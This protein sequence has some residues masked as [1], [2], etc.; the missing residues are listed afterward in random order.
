[1]IENMW[2]L[3]CL[4][5]LLAW[6]VSS[7]TP[8]LMSAR[9]KPLEI[10]VYQ[11]LG[12]TAF[13]LGLLVYLRFDIL[14]DIRGMLL[15]MCIGVTGMSGQVLYIQALKQAPLSRLSV[16]TSLY[17]AISIFL[18]VVFVGENVPLHR[19]LG[20]VCAIAS[21]VVLVSGKASVS[22]EKEVPARRWMI[23]AVGALLLWGFWA[24]L[25]KLALQT[26][27]PS[28]VIVYE[29]L[30]SGLVIAWA[31]YSLRFQ[32][33]KNVDAV[34]TCTLTSIMGMFAVFSYIYA[35]QTGPVSAVTVIT[36]MYPLITLFLA[37]IVLKERLNRRQMA[38]AIVALL[39][40]ATMVI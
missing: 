38:A 28:S 24:F 3:P 8:K 34:K 17:P 18:A 19:L 9:L 13:I 1:M 33:E 25:P 27:P 21:L 7:F 14:F 16:V 36:A 32:V 39:S 29:F 40:I 20:A 23:P 22:S 10:V 4:F 37:W 30:G 15:A 35:L 5:S 6:G 11:Y 2:I 26:L 12:Q 31:L